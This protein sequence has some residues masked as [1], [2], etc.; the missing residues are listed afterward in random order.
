MVNPTDDRV[1]ASRA[2][3][4]AT[5]VNRARALSMTPVI[6]DFG[7]VPQNQNGADRSVT[8]RLHK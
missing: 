5:D 6:F 2:P 1:V 3:A 7:G 4:S 8:V